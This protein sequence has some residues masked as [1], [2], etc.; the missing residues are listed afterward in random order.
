M[1]RSAARPRHRGVRLGP[2]RIAVMTAMTVGACSTRQQA[3]E[4]ARSPSMRVADAALAAGAPEVAL[5]VANLALERQPRDVLALTAR[6]D[7]LYAMGLRD[8]ALAAYQ[9]AVAIEPNAVAAEIGLGRVLV[10][11]DSTAA[12]T[13]FRVAL[14][15]DPDN[16]L[17]LNNLGVVRDMQGRHTEA[18]DAYLHALA[19][20][21][22][23]A[24]V[25]INL[26]TSL[27]LA[28]HGDDA[29][30]VLRV[31]AA[32]ADAVASWQ[33]ELAQALVLAGDRSLAQQ[34]LRPEAASAF[35]P[36]STT[37]QVAAAPAALPVSVADAVVATTPAAIVNAVADPA[38]RISVARM[39]IPTIAPTAAPETTEAAGMPDLPVRAPYVQLASLVSESDA[40]QEWRR[41]R[42][43]MSGLLGDREPAVVPASVHG[44]RYWRLRTLGFTTLRAA[45]DW[46]VSVKAAGLRCL[47]GRGV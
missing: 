21:P 34:V 1:R 19:A 23:S 45:S 13:A 14:A 24:D 5:R 32:N 25:R 12:E 46:C 33:K 7:A 2:V 41:L 22:N 16:V 39:E 9:T 28:G 47:A 26:A 20:S 4:P 3:A 15:R 29:D 42:T 27:A 17:A 31:V 43:R 30:Q 38:P 18:Q 6:G 37:V 44:R 35:V 40:M 10:R 36:A 8:A 11:T